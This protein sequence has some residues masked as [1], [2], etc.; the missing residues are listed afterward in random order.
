MSDEGK[1]L[2]PQS[3]YDL[4]IREIEVGLLTY[5]GTHGL[6]TDGVL[7]DVGQRITVFKNTP[8][9]LDRVSDEQRARSIYISKFIAACASGLF[10]AALNYLWDE[11]ISELRRRV[12][13]YD[14]SYFFDTAVGSP[15]KRK[16][17]NSIEDLDKIDDNELI[18]G[19]HKIGLISDLG[20]KHLDFIRYMRNW[21][22]AAHPNQ[23]Q[24]TGLQLV[25]WLETCILEVI[26]LPLSNVVVEIKRLLANIKTNAITPTEAKE[27]AAFFANLT[28]DQ[29]NSLVSGFFG[30]YTD[31]ST[32]S[33][34]RENIHRL[35]PYLWNRVD[36]PTRQQ[37]GIKYGRFVANNEQQPK[38]LALA[39]LEIVGGKSYIPDD[40][41]A[42]EIEGAIETL[43]SAHRGF[44]NFYT[45]P[46]LAR[47][48]QR[49]VGETSRIPR[50][51]ERSYV[52]ALVEVFLTN[53]N[54][55]AHNADG[56]YRDLI[57]RFTS[58]Q[59]MIAVTSFTELAIKSS[60][61]LALPKKQ[62]SVLLDL[63]R[64]KITSP[65]VLELIDEIKNFPGPFDTLAGE[66][67]IKRRLQAAQSLH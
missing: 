30:I 8:G 58:E 1:A 7:V 66:S 56:V 53:G 27:I 5:I 36:E 31:S 32:T 34:T 20:F 3:D 57:G 44:N 22:S 2:V 28:Q 10:D 49:L 39:F 65:V 62:F 15:E 60:L 18:V 21:A 33:Q 11:T 24:I 50:L 46:P 47:E 6:P 9:V 23:N 51:V 64:P 12:S 45:E 55:I 42:L 4:Q 61:Q 41:R 48:L 35:L 25:A 63:L 38:T 19:A 17:L 16:R 14:L 67:S 54:G 40:L 52:L 29:A 13:Q 59:A 43:I 37:F 26:N